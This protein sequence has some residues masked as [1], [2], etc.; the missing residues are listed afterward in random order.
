M[1]SFSSSTSRGRFVFEKK[2]NEREFS[3]SLTLARLLVDNPRRDVIY[4]YIYIAGLGSRIVQQ[5]CFFFSLFPFFFFLAIYILQKC[6]TITRFTWRWRAA[7]RTLTWPVF[8]RLSPISSEYTR[9]TNWVVV[10]RATW[11]YPGLTRCRVSLSLSTRHPFHP[12]TPR[13]V[14][15]YERSIFE[16]QSELPRIAIFSPV[17]F[18]PVRGG[19]R[20]ARD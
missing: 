9:R 11:V 13:G 10:R 16:P 14:D 17:E 1:F 4:I 18:H 20:L 2:K 19:N 6:G 3:L 5:V 15:L 8:A 12:S 7:R